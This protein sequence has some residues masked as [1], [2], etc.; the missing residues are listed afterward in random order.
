MENNYI[1]YYGKHDI[2]PVKQDI[3]DIEVHY[4]RRKKLYRQCGIPAIA[5]RNAK[6]L[7]VGPGG[8]YN[9]LAFFH[10]ESGHIDLVEA[11][12]K[13]IEDMQRLFGEQQISQD[14]YQIFPCKIEDYKTDTKYDFIIAE[15][16]IQYLY[17]QQEVIEKLQSLVAENG[18]IVIT[19]SD[20]VCIFI[21][22]L[23][24][25]IAVTM[26][27]GISEYDRKVEYLAR[28]FAPQLA[29]LRGVSRTAEDWVKDQILNPTLIN[30]TELTMLQAMDC[31]MDGFDVLGCSPR[32]F[33]DYSWYKD[34]YYDYR[35]DFREQFEQKR[36]S[37]LMA[38]MPE[39]ILPLEQAAI[40]VKSFET[41]KTIASEYEKT[42]DTQKFGDILKELEKIEELVNKNFDKNFVSAFNEIK[43]IIRSIMQGKTMEDINIEEYPNFFSAFGRTQQYIS[44]VKR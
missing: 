4:N 9:T 11:N 29:K 39:I 44:F 7:E 21:E 25:L 12:P 13:G 37:L 2:S 8:G 41:I 17:N 24:R 35:K 28:F 26:T 36:L 15:S 1:E 40:M 31:F 23:K 32:M 20:D 22:I 14:R 10:W 30:G 19:C 6:I 43:A 5:F 42:L 38:N 33:T 16:F 3:K 27:A 18:V 34:I